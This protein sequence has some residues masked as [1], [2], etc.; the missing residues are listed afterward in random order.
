[1]SLFDSSVPILF[2]IF[3]GIFRPAVTV[4][5]L[6]KAIDWAAESHWDAQNMIWYKRDP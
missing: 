6:W 1:M 4:Q 3:V 5:K 2:S